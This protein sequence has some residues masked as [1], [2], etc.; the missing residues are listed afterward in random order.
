[1]FIFNNFKKV[2]KIDQKIHPAVLASLQL[3]SM[4]I[5][6]KSVSFPLNFIFN[7]FLKIASFPCKPFASS[8]VR[9]F[10]DKAVKLHPWS[11][12]VVCSFRIRQS[13]YFSRI[14]QIIF[15]EKKL[16]CREILGNFGEFLVNFATIYSLSCGEKVHLWRKNDKYE[17]WN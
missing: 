16:S 17:V 10:Y 5:R 6:K 11:S 15:V 1:M 9:L 13:S 8:G 2:V 7:G 3:T 4:C 12:S 14:S